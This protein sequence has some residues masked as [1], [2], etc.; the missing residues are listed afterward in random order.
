MK[1][2]VELADNTRTDKNTVHSYLDLYENLLK[3][4]KDSAKHVL[5]VGIY[6]GGSIKMWADYFV[7]ATVHGLDI[8]DEKDVWDELKNKPNIELYTS[9]DAYNDYFFKY[10]LV[11]K[12]IKFDMMLDDGP[13]TLE[14]MKKFIM[15]YSQLMADDG[16]L[17]VEDVQ[18]W[19]WIDQLR[20]CVPD[21]LKDFIEV[22]D[23]RKNKNRYDDIVFTINKNK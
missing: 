23:L 12:K 21:N 5:E 4:K 14:S 3:S 8:I 1:T 15:L 17:I 16:I 2:L 7:N 6:N 22:Y 10:A 18:D 11:N 9:S 13:H 19:N 20:E